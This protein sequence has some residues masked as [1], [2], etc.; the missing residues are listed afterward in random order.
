MCTALSM[1]HLFGRTLDVEISYGETVTL[2]PRNFKQTSRY[3]ICGMARVQEDYPLF[4]DAMNE[5]GLCMAG[6]NFPESAAYF[7]EKKGKENIPSFRLIPWLLE[8][9]ASVAEALPLLENLNVTDEAFSTAIPPA[10]LHWLLADGT[11][12]LVVESC[13]DGLQVYENPVGVLTNEPPF[14]AQMKNLKEFSP[15]DRGVGLLGDGTSPA[16]FQRAV[17]GRNHSAANSV[18]Q[19]FHVMDL[20]SLPKGFAQPDGRDHYTSYTCCCD[21]KTGTYCYTTYENRQITGVCLR[22]FDLDGSR[23]LQFPLL[24][25]EKFRKE[26]LK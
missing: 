1:G 4:F 3:A 20:V 25:E 19:F 16:R 15:T 8:R 6:L 10:P 14:P 2:V 24:R 7:P 13:K 26:V 5:K 23:L 12:S 17:Y 9:C 22:D 18:S 11:H 21:T